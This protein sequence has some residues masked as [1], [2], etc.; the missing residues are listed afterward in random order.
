MCLLVNVLIL[1]FILN[2]RGSF[3]LEQGDLHMR[4]KM[5]SKK[6][7]ELRK[8]IV[9]PVGSLS[10]GL[11]RHRAILFK[12]KLILFYKSLFC[13]IVSLSIYA[14]VCYPPLFDCLSMP[15]KL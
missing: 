13:F 3:P 15:L 4:W 9:V 14:C 6:L 5:V 1:F 10:M 12:V 7:R 2:L 11:C 8:C